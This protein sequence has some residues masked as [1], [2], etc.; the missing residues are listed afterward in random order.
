MNKSASSAPNLNKPIRCQH[1]GRALTINLLC[2][3]PWLPCWQ[4]LIIP[5]TYPNLLWVVWN[6]SRF[7]IFPTWGLR[8]VYPS[9]SLMR[10]I[11][12]PLFF[13]NILTPMSRG[14]HNKSMVD[15]A[16]K[17]CKCSIGLRVLK[18]LSWNRCWYFLLENKL[19]YC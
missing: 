17:V 11:F 3:V 10:A 7:K 15:A 2:L 6:S 13:L 12:S 16:V 8:P 14:F 9:E 1:C 4:I 19:L 18:N 5:K